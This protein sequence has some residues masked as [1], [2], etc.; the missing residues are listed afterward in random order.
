MEPNLSMNAHT[1][2]KLGSEVH[3]SLEIS[4]C[5]ALT[6]ALAMTRSLVNYTSFQSDKLE[7]NRFSLF[8]GFFDVFVQKFQFQTPYEDK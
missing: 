2:A 3:F 6:S 1:T 8:H 4:V 7:H 5:S